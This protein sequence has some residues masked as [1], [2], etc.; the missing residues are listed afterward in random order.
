[1]AQLYTSAA[2]VESLF[3]GDYPRASKTPCAKPTTTLQNKIGARIDAASGFAGIDTRSV[4]I[5]AYAL[6]AAIPVASR[7]PV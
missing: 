7:P 1:M 6:L 4:P 2:A 3:R 5:C